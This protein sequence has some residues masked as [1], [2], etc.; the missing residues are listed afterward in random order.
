MSSIEIQNLVARHGSGFVLGPCDLSLAAGS[1][2]AVI[3][4]SGCG[5][6]TLLRCIAGLHPGEGR[7]GLDGQLVNDPKRI[8]PPSARRIGFVFQDGGLWPHLSVAEH[9]SFASPGLGT[10]AAEELLAQ[11]GLAGR[12][13]A[14]PGEL[15]GGE[16]Q[17]LALARALA[18]DPRILLLDEPLH[19]VDTALRGQLGVLIRKLVDARGLTLVL[20]THDRDEALA[21]ADQLVILKSGK[22]LETGSADTLL[23]QPRTAFG[24]AFLAGATCVPVSVNGGA[25]V[26]TPFGP[27]P[28][29]ADRSCP[30]ALVLLP[31]EVVVRG[32]GPVEARVLSV[33]GAADGARAL[34]DLGGHAMQVPNDGTLRI[35]TTVRVALRGAPRVLPMD[36]SEQEANA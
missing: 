2:T 29:P 1:R 10:Q 28:S 7:I 34:I 14:R 35:G 33:F 18:G 12:S 25:T 9:L 30:H 31:G 24:A 6:T 21:L 27:V 32:D 5:K 8:V 20:V 11:V 36:R 23:Q 26:A 15:S 22:V 13:R 19:S 16:A 3:G 4:P 17:R